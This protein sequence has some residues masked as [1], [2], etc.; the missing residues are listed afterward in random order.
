[1]APHVGILINNGGQFVNG[2]E[3]QPKFVME[4]LDFL[5][6][7]YTLYTHAG[8]EKRTGL[9]RDTKFHGCDMTLLADAD[10]SHLTTFLMICH[11]VDSEATDHIRQRLA[12]C[13]VV[14]FHCGNHAYF[15]AED[16][17][18]DKHD[19]VKLLHN[20][21]FTETWVFPMHAFAASYYEHLTAKPT[22]VMPYVWSPSLLDACVLRERLDVECDP[23]RYAHDAPLTLCSFEPN[24][25]V[26]KTCLVPLLIMNHFFVRAPEA[27]HR[28]YL[29]CASHLL[30]HKPFQD[31]LRFLP[32]AKSG[33]LEVCPR[34]PF[35]RAMHRLKQL[36]AAPV[37][38]GHQIANGQNYLSLECLHLGYP[39]VHNSDAIETAG[40]HYAEWDLRAASDKLAK[41]R[42][43]FRDKH[44]MYRRRADAALWTCNPRNPTNLSQLRRLLQ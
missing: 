9:A 41:F 34:V 19:V 5:G 16:V 8:V 6:V 4:A 12:H 7:P 23:A 21:W 39:L 2:S 18:F 28:C 27:V 10:L 25:N 33:K 36:G 38:I 13:K 24:L 32:L 40:Y 26:T 1:M 17:L 44:D 22:K 29:F 37:I 42:A 11:L 43:D 15:M 35:P 31:Y 20:T 3:Q 14:Q 30:N